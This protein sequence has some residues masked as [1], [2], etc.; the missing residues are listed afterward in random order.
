MAQSET[1]NYNA[2]VNTGS[3]NAIANANMPPGWLQEA[4]RHMGAARFLLSFG[5]NGASLVTGV[6]NG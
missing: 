6:Q 4:L 5:P 1:T 2:T 3:L